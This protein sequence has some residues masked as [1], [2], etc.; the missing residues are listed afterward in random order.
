MG[1]RPVSYYQLKDQLDCI[2]QSELIELSFSGPL[3]TWDDG[4][5]RSKLDRALVNCSFIE[6]FPNASVLFKASGYLFDHSQAI[7]SLD[8][9]IENKNKS[10]K[11]FNMWTEHPDYKN[12][13]R[14][15][16]FPHLR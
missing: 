12:C 13:E 7:L 11:F 16:G 14:L 10:F 1:G 4:V 8:S 5:I 15:L 9:H 6:H 3:Y 2:V